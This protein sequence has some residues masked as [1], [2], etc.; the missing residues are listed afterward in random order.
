MRN[1]VSW[2]S[3]TCILFIKEPRTHEGPDGPIGYA[4]HNVLE[5]N[6]IH[7]SMWLCTPFPCTTSKSKPCAPEQEISIAWQRDLQMSFAAVLVCDRLRAT[8]KPQ[9]NAFR[10]WCQKKQTRQQIMQAG[11]QK[12]QAHFRRL[13]IARSPDAII[14]CSGPG[15]SFFRVSPSGSEA[16]P[17]RFQVPGEPYR[18]PCVP[19]PI[20]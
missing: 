17:Q 5:S 4:Q 6:L 19:C 20:P 13:G 18:W 10:P 16:T 3:P 7:R 15:F 12:W 8:I 1:L 9:Q 14:V 11:S 2:N